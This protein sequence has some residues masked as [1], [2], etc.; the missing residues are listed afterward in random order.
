MTLPGNLS[1]FRSRC[2]GLPLLKMPQGT[3]LIVH[4]RC[5]ECQKLYTWN[6]HAFVLCET[7]DDCRKRAFEIV[8]ENN[9]AR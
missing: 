7:P 1:A 8:R 9:A 5:S 2:C 6:G 3:N 4:W